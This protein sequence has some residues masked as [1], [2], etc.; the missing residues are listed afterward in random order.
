MKIRTWFVPAAAAAL[1]LPAALLR[2]DGPI[3]TDKQK[4]P[5]NKTITE[6][7]LRAARAGR[8]TMSVATPDAQPSAEPAKGEGA[9]SAAAKEEPSE[10][11]K[12]E[13]RRKEIQDQVD[14]QSANIRKLREEIDTAQREL[15]DLGDYTFSLPGTNTGRRAALVKLIEDAN[16]MIKT[17]NEKIDQ[18]E[19]EARRA[20]V[21]V[22]RP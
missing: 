11:D 9:G 5:P 15:N 1:L 8:G 22:S 12:R 16:G 18:L 19:D 6:D 14:Y 2:A 3:P 20:G 21:S 4:K 17:S 7:D 10:S 13:A